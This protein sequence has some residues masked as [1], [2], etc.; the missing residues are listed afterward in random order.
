[1]LFFITLLPIKYKYVIVIGEALFVS[2]TVIKE[3][4]PSFVP[5]NFICKNVQSSLELIVLW[6][7]KFHQHTAYLEETTQG[8]IN[9][10]T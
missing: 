1:M 9:S 5:G 2:Y 3:Q 10:L 7:R 6:Y 8:I 4:L